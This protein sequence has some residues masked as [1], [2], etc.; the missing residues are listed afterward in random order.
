MYSKGLYSYK[1]PGALCNMKGRTLRINSG[2]DLS[3]VIIKAI[4]ELH[5]SNG[6]TLRSIE[7]FLR[8]TFTINVDE[9]TDLGHQLHQSVKRAVKNGLIIQEGRMYKLKKIHFRRGSSDSLS[10]S[11]F[12]QSSLCLSSPKVNM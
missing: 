6:S 4:K 11:S 10:A 1:D 7:K 2:T 9:G 8:Q 3:K 12:N 5:E